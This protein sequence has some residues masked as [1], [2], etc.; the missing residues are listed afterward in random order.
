[1]KPFQVNESTTWL[2]TCAK[3]IESLLA[4]EI[5]QLGGKVEKE[6]HLGVIWTGS[7][8]VAYRV[9]LWSRLASRLLLPLLESPVNSV[10]EMYEQARQI[11]W[12]EVFRSSSAFRVDF[13]WAYSFY[14]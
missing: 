8:D 11:A 7:L 14:Q 6:T 1:M 9:C 13:F 12:P 2:A 4:N 3:G 5:S 10:D